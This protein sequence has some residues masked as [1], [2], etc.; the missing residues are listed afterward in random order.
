M[1]QQDKN[2]SVTRSMESLNPNL[3]PNI[4]EIVDFAMVDGTD[5][6]YDNPTNFNKAW[7]NPDEE[8]NINWWRAIKKEFSKMINHKVWERVKKE[9][10]QKTE[11][12]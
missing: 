4:E 7:D 2:I 1:N 9:I 12:Y 3:R 5:E 11:D 6:L 10:F 8:E